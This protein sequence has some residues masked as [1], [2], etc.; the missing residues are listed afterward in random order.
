MR[1]H[2]QP[3]D[4]IRDVAVEERTQD[5]LR[6]QRKRRSETE[7]RMCRDSPG[8]N[9]GRDEREP[10]GGARD[11]A[12]REAGATWNPLIGCCRR[13]DHETAAPDRH[14]E[15]VDL[16]SLDDRAARCVLFARCKRLAVVA[17]VQLAAE[18]G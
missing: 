12:I 7:Q 15:G 10:V 13:P 9:D 4:V 8:W 5:S 11:I 6:G 2:A 16:L 18:G 1:V 3:N 14:A 17:G